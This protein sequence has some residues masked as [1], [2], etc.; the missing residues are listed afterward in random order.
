MYNL[1]VDEI[2]MVDGGGD[3]AYSGNGS[4]NPSNSTN[5]GGQGGGK[6]GNPNT[7]SPSCTGGVLTGALSGA[8]GGAMAGGPVGAL[9]GA[10]I[11][12]ALGALGGLGGCAQ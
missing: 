9:G 4:Y 10:I 1:S 12:G 8:A 3:G 7:A 11:G 5:Y 2:S 6:I